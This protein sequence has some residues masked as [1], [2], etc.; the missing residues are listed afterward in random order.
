MFYLCAMTA[1]IKKI[2]KTLF[3]HPVVDRKPIVGSKVVTDARGR[4][5]PI[6]QSEIDE[7]L[8]YLIQ[9]NLIGN[10]KEVRSEKKDSSPVVSKENEACSIPNWFSAPISSLHTPSQAEIKIIEQLIRYP[11]KWYS[12][13]SFEGFKTNNGGF[14]RFDFYIPSLDLIIEY[15]G[16]RYHNTEEAIARDKIKTEFCTTYGIKLVR[17][18]KQHY[19]HL[20]TQIAGLL[21]K[22]GI[23]KMIDTHN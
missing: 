11:I 12:E 10:P 7:Y 6:N 17:Y 23:Y 16:E 19:Y 2:F 8:K 13:V 1:T 22:Y 3:G 21:K 18:N 4:K 20:D 9:E 14:Y 5:W 15:D